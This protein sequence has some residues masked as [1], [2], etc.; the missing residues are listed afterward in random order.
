MTNTTSETSYIEHGCTLAVSGWEIPAALTLPA[1]RSDEPLPSAI[2]LIPGSLFSD[3]NGDYPAWNSFPGV[4]KHL[5]R[6]LSARGH[7]VYRFA[8]LGPGTG[9]VATD[10]ERSAAVRTWGGRLVIA[11]AALTAMRAELTSRGIVATKV[12][13]AGHSEGSVV[14]SQLAT[15]ERADELDGVV[16]LAGPS[17]G[18]LEIMREQIGAWT[19]PEQHSAAKERLDAVIGF[20]RRGE[21]IPAEFAGGGMGAGALASMPDDARRYMRECDATDP[22]VLAAAMTQPVLVVQGGNDTSVPAH[23]GEA[24]RDVLSARPSAETEYLFVPE[25]QHMF[26]VAPEGTPLQEAFGYPGETDVRIADG[27]DRWIRR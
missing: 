5:A 10:A 7:A 8:K 4:Y 11:G 16:L 6:Q 2:L 15:S 17:V 12:I 3:V 19:P 25:V 14:V 27:I 18:I 13:G 23:H 26:K 9:S 1:A 20:V 24:L 22:K 21:A